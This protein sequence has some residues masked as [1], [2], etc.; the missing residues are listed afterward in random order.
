M[1]ITCSICVS[2]IADTP[3]S[4][5]TD[6]AP[7]EHLAMLAAGTL[8]CNHSFHS[9]CIQPWLERHNT[10]PNC[11]SLSR[12]SSLQTVCQPAPV[13]HASAAVQ[14][15]RKSNEDCA[16]SVLLDAYAFSVVCD[17]HCGSTVA[18][19]LG[20]SFI[21]N[22]HQ[23]LVS[24]SPTAPAEQLLEIL[25]ASYTVALGEVD[26]RGTTTGLGNLR[27]GSTIT[28]VMLQ[29][30]TMVC[31]TL[32]L[33][34]CRAGACN[35]RT[36]AILEG[37]QL[38]SSEQHPELSNQCVTRE[39]SF[40]DILEQGRIATAV[41]E[42]GWLLAAT[43]RTDV[44]DGED[45]CLGKITKSSSGTTF[46]FN[47]PSRGV[48]NP[49]MYPQAV[50]EALTI[51]QRVPELVA[52]QLPTSFN[53]PIVLFCAC[54]G[55]FSH[56]A[57]GSIEAFGTCVVDPEAYMAS[58]DLGC[59]DGTCLQQVVSDP[60]YESH[61]RQAKKWLP[62][63]GIEWAQD[64]TKCCYELMAKLAPD[65]GWLSAVN[66]SWANV[67]RLRA[68]HGGRVPSLIE[69][70]EAAIEMAT[71][72]AVLLMSDDNVSIETLVVGSH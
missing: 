44:M 70:P 30:A 34:D 39:H 31:A 24:T 58:S 60:D 63:A 53:T 9:G 43:Q 23:Q 48:E 64:P 47:E 71:N 10:C 21:D 16:G 57:F 27:C 50:A 19:I 67:E 2:D 32:Q 12:T 14:G 72:L 42:Q 49:Q 46:T 38:C 40:R 18:T 8:E 65:R 33:G 51:A 25:H 56:N 20:N 26:K 36:G 4:K 6:A 22:L 61:L 55:F 13:T 11:R 7:A 15:S 54:D 52:W 17:G 66:L 59:L 37:K 69:A 45:R 5:T 41:H 1:S 68:S 3:D 62:G 29:R 35:G 28:A